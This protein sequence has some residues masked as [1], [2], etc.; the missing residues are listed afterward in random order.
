MT[1]LKKCWLVRYASTQIKVREWYFIETVKF[2]PLSTSLPIAMTSDV[3]VVTEWFLLAACFSSESDNLCNLPFSLESDDKSVRSLWF[4]NK[5]LRLCAGL[6]KLRKLTIF[7]LLMWAS[8]L[9]I[10][11]SADLFSGKIRRLIGTAEF[12]NK[13][14][15][16]FFHSLY[17]CLGFSH[18]FFRC[19]TARKINIHRFV[20]EFC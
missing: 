13:Q 1:W 18:I 8:Y 4:P 14:T 15:S 19:K 2:S 17:R 11:L 16:V 7:Y 9:E 5:L 10:D 3:T 12:C 6:M 20:L